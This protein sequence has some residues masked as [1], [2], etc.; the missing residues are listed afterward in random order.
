MK[1]KVGF[2]HIDR[3]RVNHQITTKFSYKCSHGID[4]K[5][6]NVKQEIGSDERWQQNLKIK[7]FFQEIQNSLNTG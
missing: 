7:I 4:A 6:Q 2:T 1:I 5:C 3:P